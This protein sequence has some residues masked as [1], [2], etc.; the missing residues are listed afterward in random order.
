MNQT[1]K[2]FAKNRCLYQLI[3]PIFQG[4]NRLFVLSFENENDRT[5]HPTYF[6][7]KVEI[8]DYNVMIDSKNFFDQTINS[9]IET[10]EKIRKIQV[11]GMTIQMVVC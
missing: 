9:M 8:K 11:T 6:L 10:Y 7:S 4:I 5:S 3:N 2:P 1:S